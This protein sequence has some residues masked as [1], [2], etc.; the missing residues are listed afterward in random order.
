MRDVISGMEGSDPV[1]H[2]LAEMETM[3]CAMRIK[4]KRTEDGRY[5]HTCV[6]MGEKRSRPRHNK[7][8]I[9]PS[10]FSPSSMKCFMDVS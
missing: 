3:F 2:M 6:L 1:Q 9:S 8:K 10:L 5:L 7:N 4:V